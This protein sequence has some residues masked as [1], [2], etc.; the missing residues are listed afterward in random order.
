[1]EKLGVALVGLGKLS[2]EQ[3]APALK[4]TKH[5]RLAALVSGTPNKLKEWGAKYKIPEESRYSYENFDDI[6]ENPDVDIVYVVLPNAM[7]GEF[8]IRAARAGKHVLCEKPME[9]SVRKCEQMIEACKRAKVQLAVAYR[10]QFEPHHL[11]M[12]RLAHEEKFG[13]VKLIEASFGFKIGEPVQWRLKKALSGGGSLMDVGIYALQAARYITQEE[14]IEV[15]AFE[16]K[17]D[18]KKF[19]EVDESIFWTMKFPSGVMANCGC[20]YVADDMDRLRVYADEGWFELEPAYEYGGLKA[21]TSDGP[22]KIKQTDHFATEMDEFAKCVKEGKQIKISGEEGLKDVRAL[23][24]VYES[25]R[26]GKP[27]KLTS[28]R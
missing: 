28:S 23:M 3:I 19:K 10:L 27:I 15:T 8:T 1:M 22:L 6:A 17:T 20:N 11:E 14:P 13:G 12:M 26:K 16:T 5:C 7:H 25:I 9:V 18:R 24:A 2:E 21:R 4:K